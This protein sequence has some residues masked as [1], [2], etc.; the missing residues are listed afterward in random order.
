MTLVTF[1]FFDLSCLPGN[2]IDVRVDRDSPEIA[3]RRH[4]FYAVIQPFGRN[5][6]ISFCHSFASAQRKSNASYAFI[7]SRTLS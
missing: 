3:C 5:L 2:A 4:D 6:P 1:A 7:M